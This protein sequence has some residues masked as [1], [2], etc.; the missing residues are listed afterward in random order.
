MTDEES[1]SAIVVKVGGSLYDLADLGRRLDGVL[2]GL[3][4]RRV[5]L[6][7][8]GGRLAEVIRTLDETHCL[9]EEASHWLALRA[10]AVNATFLAALL[11]H[12]KTRIV[13][14][15]EEMD[16]AWRHHPL[17]MLDAHALACADETDPAR[18]PH[19]WAVSSDAVALRAASLIRAHRLLLLKSVTLPAGIGWPEASRRGIVDRFFPQLV[20]SGCGASVKI[21]VRNLR[22][23]YS[24]S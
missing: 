1:R 18:L 7:P 20:A 3:G 21:E 13:G 23:G 8:G 12:R 16:T 5:L 24:G 6:V 11:A 9:G 19:T 4:T 2:D 17:L 22:D 15:I 14:T 10:L